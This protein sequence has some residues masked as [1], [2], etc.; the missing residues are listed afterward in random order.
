MALEP[1]EPM[2]RK[3]DALR[4]GIEGLVIDLARFSLDELRER[5]AALETE[6]ERCRETIAAKSK[7][8]DAADAVFRR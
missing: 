4:L 6:I 8:R 3:A 2:A 7:S 5:I 1:D